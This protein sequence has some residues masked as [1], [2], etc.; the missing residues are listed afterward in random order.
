MF[1][2]SVVGSYCVLGSQEVIPTIRATA[3][4]A[5][6]KHFVDFITKLFL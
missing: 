2:S 3:A 6:A 1:F 4:I 5:R